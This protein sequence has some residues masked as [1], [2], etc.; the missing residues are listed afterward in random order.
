MPLPENPFDQLLADGH[1]PDLVP[2]R[3]SEFLPEDLAPMEDSTIGDLW[4]QSADEALRELLPAG[5][6]HPEL[7]LL[8]C[9]RKAGGQRVLVGLLIREHQPG[10]VLVN[11]TGT[12]ANPQTKSTRTGGGVAAQAL[13]IAIVTLLP[14]ILVWFN[15][16]VI[17]EYR[18]QIRWER[19]GIEVSA[20]V[21]KKES[22]NTPRAPVSYHLTLD[23]EHAGQRYQEKRE[24]D[25]NT[26]LL[27][28]EGG[29]VLVRIDPDQPATPYFQGDDQAWIALMLL[30]TTDGILAILIGVAILK[31]RRSQAEPVSPGK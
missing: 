14:I 23:Y 16:K 5:E 18:E 1:E 13:V 17:S 26:H 12:F 24:V 10:R 20:K 28:S 31:C 30:I 21:L 15:W 11:H 19:E 22:T 4:G 9:V 29:A 25:H 8:P 7:V 6:W 27:S 3:I 2:R